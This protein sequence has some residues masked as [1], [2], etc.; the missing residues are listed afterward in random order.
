MLSEKALYTIIIAIILIGG[1][2]IGVAYYKE[3]STSSPTPTSEGT[4]S[5]TLMIT[6]D[7]WFKNASIATDLPAFFVVLPNGQLNSSAVI[8]LPAHKLITLTIINYDSM[9]SSNVGINGTSNNSSY[10]KVVG[11]VGGVEY[12]YNGSSSY[13]NATLSGNSSNNITINRGQGWAVSSVPW[14]GGSSGGWELS[15]TFTIVQNGQ[16]ILNI[17]TFGGTN[18]SGGVT[19]FAQF[20]LNNTGTFTWQCYSP[21][22]TSPNGWGGNMVTAGWMTGVVQVVS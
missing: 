17:P 7:N 12:I 21:C 5:L 16:I 1:L 19:T 13:V 18:P 20:Y 6:P 2:G 22:G 9:L 11:T 8:T 3:V 4:T 10:A 14:V 15:H